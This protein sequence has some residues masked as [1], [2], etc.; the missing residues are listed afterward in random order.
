MT[1]LSCEL[2]GS[3]LIFKY[4]LFHVDASSVTHRVWGGGGGGVIQS[5]VHALFYLAALPEYIASLRAE[6][7]EEG[8]S[9]EGLDKTDKV[10]SFIKE[11]Q[12]MNPIGNRTVLLHLADGL[13]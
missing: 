10:D 7:E 6:V 5:F 1:R 12:R 3:S 11:S 13:R 4:E 9:K 2:R 8:R